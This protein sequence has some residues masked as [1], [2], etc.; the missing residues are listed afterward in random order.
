MAGVDRKYVGFGWGLLFQSRGLNNNLFRAGTASIS[1]V[2]QIA[3][4]QL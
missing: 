1:I 4:T 2:S 3:R